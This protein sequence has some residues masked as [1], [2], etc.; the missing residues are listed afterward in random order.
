M[1]IKTKEEYLE[2]L[3]EMKPTVYMRGE[4][5]EQIWKDPRFQSTINLVGR[6]HDFAFDEEFK[7]LSV[8][9]SPL[10]GEPI[11]RLSMHIQADREDAIKKVTL[12]RE[13]TQRHICAWCQS[14]V[15]SLIWA[16]TYD[17]DQKYGTSYHERFIEQVKFLQQNDYDGAWGM[18]DPKGDRS[19]TPSQQDPYPGVRIVERNSRGITVRG[20]KVH[21]SYGPTTREIFVFPCR[22]LREDEKDF[23]VAFALPVDTKGITFITRPAPGHSGT[24]GLMDQPLGSAIGGVEAMTVFEDVFVPWERVFLCG[25]WDMAHLIPSY[26]GAI[27]RSTKCACLAGHTDLV[28]GI[29]ALTAEVNGLGS[30]VT[31]IRDKLTGMMMQAET[32]YG[33]ALG[34]SVNGTAHPSGVWVADSVVA[35]SGFHFIK[36]A[37]AEHIGLLHDI[38]GGLIVTM[39]T[40]QDYRNPELRAHMDTYL[41]GSSRY[42]TEERL[43]VLHLAQEVGASRWTGYFLGWAISGAGSPAANDLTVRHGYDL[44]KRIAI[45]KQ[46]AGIDSER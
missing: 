32:A 10:V 9:H 13:V 18:M 26:F 11:R 23:A 33:C 29:L 42:T 24:A 41:C 14:N 3:K 46:W 20:C 39:P 28:C 36:G 37:T 17:T 21:T 31:H 5:V 27:H 4:R 40:E 12:T 7:A 35:N 34:S 19:L 43:R 6:N 1:A 15:L 38:A 16:A 45:A 30:G 44:Q 22:A 25:E 8:A 2:D